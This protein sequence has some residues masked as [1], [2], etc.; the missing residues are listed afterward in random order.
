MVSSCFHFTFLPFSSS[1]FH[2]Q[3]ESHDGPNPRVTPPATCRFSPR[4]DLNRTSAISWRDMHDLHA[5]VCQPPWGVDL[6][7]CTLLPLL[8]AL[9]NIICLTLKN[10]INENEYT[11]F[12]VA[13]T[14][15]RP[16]LRFP[17]HQ[18]SPIHCSTSNFHASTQAVAHFGTRAKSLLHSLIS[19]TPTSEN[20]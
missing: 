14:L 19:G 7:C 6:Q 20:D 1:F 15:T 10:N 11:E 17:Y 8:S 4:R 3:L 12:G 2:H 5:F 18:L 9:K 16:Y 13:R